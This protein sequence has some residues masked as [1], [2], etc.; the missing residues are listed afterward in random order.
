M[1]MFGIPPKE[2]LLDYQ[3]IITTMMSSTYLMLGGM[4]GQFT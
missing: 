1:D 4:S 3:V 2:K